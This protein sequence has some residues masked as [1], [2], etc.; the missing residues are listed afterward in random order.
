VRID[1]IIRKS[2][3][4]SD[5]LAVTIE[6]FH[7]DFPSLDDSQETAKA[8]KYLADRLKSRDEEWTEKLRNIKE[9]WDKI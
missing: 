9:I 2:D 1:K 3:E 8:K 6:F 5:R 4:Q 7:H